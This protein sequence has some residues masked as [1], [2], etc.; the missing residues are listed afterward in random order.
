MTPMTSHRHP[1]PA[2]G[3]FETLLVVR[4][5]PVAQ[6]AHLERL[7]ASLETVYGTGLPAGSHRVVT[8]HA[9]GLELGRLRLTVIPE[10]TS[11]SGLAVDAAELG[12]W[13]HFPQ[14]PVSLRPHRVSGGLGAHKWAD[15]GALPPAPPGEAPLLID[16]D[17]VLEAAWANVFAV[18][19]GAL[20]TPPLDGRILPG[21]TRATMI[22]VAHA[23][24]IEASERPLSLAELGEA[25]EVFLTN[26][27]RGVEVIDSVD[28]RA[29]AAPG[30]VTSALRDDLRSTW[31]LSLAPTS[32]A[33]RP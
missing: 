21:V 13:P 16:G 32:T 28:G 27:I 23:R 19:R 7:E 17:E 12:D 9:A 5:K 8:E 11:E 18:R 20:F 1:D 30:P 14:Q 6:A 3:I 2:Q 31:R 25:D 33:S 15:R 29:I 22:E 4:G 10:G 24:G 26:S